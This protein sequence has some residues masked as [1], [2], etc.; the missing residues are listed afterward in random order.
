MVDRLVTEQKI[1][2]ESVGPAT[3]ADRSAG[4]PHRDLRAERSAGPRGGPALLGWVPKLGVWAWSFVGAV[5]TTI[6]LVL[7]LGAVSE[8]V[9]PLTFAAVLAVI[10]KPL[11]GMGR[12]IMQTQMHRRTT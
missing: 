8:I 10:F 9:L 1:E 11:V 2:T 6:I 4:S 12:L 3:V 7:A 5:A